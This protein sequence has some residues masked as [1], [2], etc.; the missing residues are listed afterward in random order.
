MRKDLINFIF[1]A[2]DGGVELLKLPIVHSSRAAMFSMFEVQFDILIKLD[3]TTDFDVSTV[4]GSVEMFVQNLE[5]MMENEGIL[6]DPE[7]FALFSSMKTRMKA[8]APKMPEEL[9]TR[10]TSK[11]NGV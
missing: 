1:D 10:L 3:S 2:P 5:Y 7:L 11:V 9:R 6:N 4:E 8:V